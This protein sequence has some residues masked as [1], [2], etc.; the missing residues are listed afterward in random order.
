M[1]NNPTLQRTLDCDACDVHG[2]GLAD[3]VGTVNGL[4]LNRGVVPQD[5]RVGGRANSAGQVLRKQPKECAGLTDAH[6]P[7]WQ[8]WYPGRNAPIPCLLML[9][10]P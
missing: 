3:A 2:L 10:Q 7:C 5:F 4:L 6:T 9:H 1:P 8:A